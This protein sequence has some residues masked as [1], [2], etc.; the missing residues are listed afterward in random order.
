MRKLLVTVVIIAALVTLSNHG[1]SQRA[2]LP[3]LRGLTLSHAQSRARAE[4]FNR[5][6]SKD[7]TKEDRA[8]LLAGN[9]KV[10]TQ[11]PAPGE[12]AV[13]TPVEVTVVKTDEG[14]PA[15]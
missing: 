14:C 13:T 7:A 8:Q 10:C 11:T 4:G 9:W 15:G 1:K 12:H 2:T 5:L 3:D 6:E